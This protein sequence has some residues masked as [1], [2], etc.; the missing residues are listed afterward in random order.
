MLYSQGQYSLLFDLEKKTSKGNG[1]EHLLSA[2]YFGPQ[3]YMRYF[4]DSYK[5]M[6]K[7]DFFQYTV[8][9]WT[10]IEMQ[11]LDK[12]I[13]GA[14]YDVICWINVQDIFRDNE[15]LLFWAVIKWDNI[16]P[17]NLPFLAHAMLM[18]LV[19]FHFWIIKL[20]SDV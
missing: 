5:V 1:K 2:W 15:I 20:V 4:L 11:A 3:Y 13:I 16:F 19:K 8:L 7:N 10:S 14:Q 18:N 6:R 12:K 9:C 17:M